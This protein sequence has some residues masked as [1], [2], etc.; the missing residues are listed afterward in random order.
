METQNMER[1]ESW[2]SE[3]L[4][5]VCA[6]ANTEG[7]ALIIGI[8]DNGVVI[9][10]K[11]P[12]YVMKLIP[13]DI[14]NK[15]DV[16]VSVEAVIIENRTCIKITVERGDSYI[17]LDGVFYKRVGN[18][19]QKVKGK[20]LESWIL[21]NMRMT[22][23]DLP[24]KDVKIGDLSQEAIDFFV[25]TGIESGRMSPE[26]AKQDNTTI[27]EHYKLMDENG[28]RNSAAILFLKEPRFSYPPAVVRIGA[29]TE[30]DKFIRHDLISCAV[31]LQPDRA[32]KVMLD[33]Y[34][35]GKDELKG[36]MLVRGYPY[37]V[38]ALREALINA[39]IHRDYSGRIATYVRVYPDR[40]K[41]SNPGSLPMGWTTENLFK[42]HKSE[43][44]NPTIA[45]VFHD[46]GFIE[47][48]GS[49]I[50][51]IRDEC[52]AKGLPEPEYEVADDGV[53][54]T[55][56]LPEKK[57]DGMIIKPAVDLSDLTDTETTVYTII[58]KG[59]MSTTSEISEVTGIPLRT[60]E[61]S[62]ANLVE[63]GLVQRVGGK[64]YGKWVAVPKSN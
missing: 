25:N 9:G 59:N 3:W 45:D 46:M 52:K 22:W 64:R 60:A 49:G 55:F 39:I 13:D 30:D 54:I 1:K 14:R 12:H 57:D 62:V 28:L 4:K 63:K 2:S 15:L 42:C 5:T 33:Q 35:L 32:L 6:F 47:Q 23:A 17:D 44:R 56:R 26:A 11:D 29:F 48:W 50:E 41:I 61:R 19:T 53:E 18:T 34:I 16:K 24:V 36:A 31:V 38:R 37:P 51:T 8:R 7:G 43:P 58:S 20:G 40:V 10:V 21:S 27:L